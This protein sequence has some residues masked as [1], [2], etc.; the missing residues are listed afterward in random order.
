MNNISISAAKSIRETLG[1]SKLIILAID[2]EGHQHI[3]THGKTR[4]DAAW[5]AKAGNNLKETL[6]WP[7]ELCKATPVERLCKNCVFYKSDW[8]SWCFNG[9]S[10]DGTRGYCH[11]EPNKVS[12][13]N[14][15]TCRHFE[16]NI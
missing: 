10:K 13:A 16:P 7:E 1:A 12:V 4:I 6:G 2:E 5:A 3:A 14:D 15:Q 9:W 8:G 11:A